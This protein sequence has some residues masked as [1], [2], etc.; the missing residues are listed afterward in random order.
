MKG[1]KKA[2]Q[3]ALVPNQLS[4][5]AFHLGGKEEL[6][7][8]LEMV[9]LAVSSQRWAGFYFR[10]GPEER[11]H[12]EGI[13]GRAQTA[14]AMIVNHEGKFSIKAFQE[15]VSKLEVSRENDFR[16]GAR[17]E[18]K[19]RAQLV[20]ERAESVKL[21]IVDNGGAAEGVGER[22]FASVRSR[23]ARR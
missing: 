6:F 15:V 8:K 11:L 5:Q 14:V 2:I 18:V 16:I 20:A 19:F 10:R 23:N 4:R 21:S 9:A 7:A 12:A 17:A 3:S 22:L 1:K 13:A